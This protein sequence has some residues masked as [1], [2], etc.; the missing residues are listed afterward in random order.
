[1]NKKIQRSDSM[2]IGIVLAVVGGYLDAYTFFGRGGVF[3]NAQTGNFVLL[4]MDITKGNL[5]GVFMYS[6]PII[7]FI[8]GVLVAEYM[9]KLF[10][11]MAWIHWRQM[12][13]IIEILSL[14]FVI[15]IPQ[16]RYDIIA[17]VLIAFICSLQVQSFRK[18]EGNPYATTMCTGNL[19]SG[20]DLLFKYI[21]GDKKALSDGLK[22][23]YIILAFIVGAII[24]GSATLYIYSF[25][26]S[27]PILLLII[28]IFIMRKK[29]I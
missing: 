8:F 20:T 6:L 25:A 15:I 27:M 5:H 7:A 11:G 18:L 17:N 13:L 24:G 4:G 22:Y 10:S 26:L 29:H 2:I 28:S 3:A 16:G 21:N 1:M 23:Y 12:V 14:G 19:R 9:R